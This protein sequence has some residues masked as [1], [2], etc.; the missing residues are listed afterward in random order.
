MARVL[1]GMSNP[2]KAASNG[3]DMHF[4]SAVKDVEKELFKKDMELRDKAAAHVIKVTKKKLAAPSGDVPREV[5]KSFTRGLKKKTKRF[6]TEV[7]VGKPGFHAFNVEKGH[8]IIRGGVKVGEAK[9]HEF[10]RPSFEDSAP[11]IKAI[12]SEER[13]SDD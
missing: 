1:K 8:D 10:L 2:F 6:Y 4:Y 11:T 9:P 5:R 3:I 12:L 13:I 7:G